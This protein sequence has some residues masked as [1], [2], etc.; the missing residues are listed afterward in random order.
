M[1]SSELIE[2]IAYRSRFEHIYITGTQSQG[3]YGAVYDALIGAGGRQTDIAIRVLDLPAT[4]RESFQEKILTHIEQWASV[5]DHDHVLSVL[6]FGREPRPWIAT[7]TVENRLTDQSPMDLVALLPTAR[8]LVDAVSHLHRNDRTHGGLDPV[9]VVFTERSDGGIVRGRPLLNNPGLVH[10]YRY[11]FD[12][13]D[14]LDPRY[15][16]PEFYDD[17][18]GAIDAQT[19]IYQLGAVLYR[20]FTGNPPFRGSINQIKKAVLTAEPAKPSTRG[21]ST[22]FDTV[23][24]KAMAKEKLKR[25]ET[26]EQ[27]QQDLANIAATRDYE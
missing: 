22:L 17:G 1:G 11:A 4:D 10:L 16:A 9:A 23:L 25:Y 24:S 3:R 6:D 27:L 12:P 18:Y 21:G 5:S 14:Y 20:L 13:A 8:Q 15:A 26:I 7:P 19:D 2:S